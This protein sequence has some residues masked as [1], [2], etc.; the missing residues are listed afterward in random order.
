MI[1]VIKRPL[2][3]EKNAIHA[4]YNTYSFE[5]DLRSS[6]T[7]IKLAIEQAFRVKVAGVRT[8]LFRGRFFRKQAGLGKPQLRK[9]ALVKLVEGE[10]IALFEGA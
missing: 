1:E 4:E 10:K 8:M 5:V 3:S 7:D 9:K 6:K 2:V